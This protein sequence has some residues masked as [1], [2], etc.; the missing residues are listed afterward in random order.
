MYSWKSQTKPAHEFWEQESDDEP[1]DIISA[2]TAT[3][4]EEIVRTRSGYIAADVVRG[5][6][7]VMTDN[8]AIAGGRLLH[9]T[10]DLVC[11]GG[12]QIWER[13]LYD[14]ALEHIGIASPRIFIYLSKRLADL[15]A[16][17]RSLPDEDMW[18]MAAYQKKVA[19][20][21][22]VMKDC[23]RRGK[24]K[25]PRIDAATHRNSA[26]LQGFVKSTAS[27]AVAKVWKQREDMDVLYIAATE[28]AA[29]I[30][31]G[32]TE[33][34]LYW[35]KW[36]M[37]EEVAYKREFAAQASQGAGSKKAASAAAANVALSMVE[38]GPAGLKTNKRLHVGY[39]IAEVLA[40]IY[41]DIAMQGHIKMHEEF[42]ALINLYRSTTAGLTARRKIDILCLMTQ[43]CAEVPRWKVAAAPVLVR[44][45]IVLQRMT[46]QA[47]TFFSEVLQHPALTKP[48]SKKSLKAPPKQ[49]P[50]E[51]QTPYDAAMDAYF[52]RIGIK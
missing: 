5:L 41:K 35:L 12:F 42:Q 36:L 43:I 52:A 15:G 49:K 1:D 20:I 37:E 23:P 31:D 40:E 38:R 34:A 9:Y 39:F 3:Q 4:K 2:L 30:A 24:P 11:S 27:K 14:F 32:A 46:D 44:D 16:Y 21:A 22:L 6:Y 18:R 17:S 45:S 13:F 8:G 19:E 28:M 26:W 7:Q 33:K 48:L 50:K 25:I 29:A 51:E 47:P 10:A